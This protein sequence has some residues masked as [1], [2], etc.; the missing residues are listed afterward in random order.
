[1]AKVQIHV[2]D[3]SFEPL[4]VLAAWPGDGAASTHFIGRVR[5]TGADGRALCGLWLEHYPAM[6]AA[7]L[8]RICDGERQRYGASHVLV[9]HRV[10]TVAIGDAIVLVA[11]AA[12]HR[13]AAMEACRA[14][15]EQLKHRA[16][17]WKKEC[18]VEGGGRWVP[19]NTPYRP[20]E[21]N[22]RQHAGSPRTV[23]RP[24][25]KLIFME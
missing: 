14:V 15:L 17:F 20:A 16:P 12:D 6:T 13:G 4:Q 24:G 2:T 5:P 21:E 19:G 22:V 1:M 7:M 10:G 3:R 11:V 9:W 23:P 18:W 25:G 8:Q